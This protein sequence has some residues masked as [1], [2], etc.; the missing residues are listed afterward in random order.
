MESARERGRDEEQTED[1]DGKTGARERDERFARKET[2]F[3]I[4][5]VAGIIGNVISYIRY[6]ADGGGRITC[7]RGRI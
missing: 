4:G 7:S 5:R 6:A 1:A 2:R 3:A